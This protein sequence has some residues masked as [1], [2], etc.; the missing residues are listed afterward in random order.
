MFCIFIV[1]VVFSYFLESIRLSNHYVNS[2]FYPRRLFLPRMNRYWQPKLAPRTKC[3]QS[4]LVLLDHFWLPKLVL[5]D[6]FYPF[7]LRSHEG[8]SERRDTVFLGLP[9]TSALPVTWLPPWQRHN[10]QVSWQRIQISV[11]LQ[12]PPTL[13]DT[14]SQC[15]LAFLLF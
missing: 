14:S 7:H 1:F 6:H 9:F 10:P 5:P 15:L 12:P 4:K 8:T 13:L 3:W 2:D 11:F